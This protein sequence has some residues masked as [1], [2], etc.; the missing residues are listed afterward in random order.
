MMH[1]KLMVKQQLPQMLKQLWVFSGQLI[2]CTFYS[3]KI[4]GKV[5][6]A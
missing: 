6:V 4:L 2:C 5:A 1:Q 3:S